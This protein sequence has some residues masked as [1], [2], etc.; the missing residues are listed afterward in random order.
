V[1]KPRRPI[2]VG[3]W[4]FLKLLGDRVLASIDAETKKPRETMGFT[5][6]S[7]ERLMRFELTTTTLATLCSTN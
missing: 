2:R 1:R 4:G 5:G 7:Q 6:F 3:G